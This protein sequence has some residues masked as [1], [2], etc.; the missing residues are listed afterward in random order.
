MPDH[1]G[2]TGSS[3]G[4]DQR[5]RRL[6]ELR[7]RRRPDQYTWDSP[8]LDTI[9]ED[10]EYQ[11]GRTR[12]ERAPRYETRSTRDDNRARERE[13]AREQRERDL[14]RY[15][16]ERDAERRRIAE[17]S[18]RERE[19]ER[20]RE[21]QREQERRSEYSGYERSGGGSSRRDPEMDAIQREMEERYDG[22][23]RQGGNRRS[24]FDSK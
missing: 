21:R 5:N 14:A 17:E 23:R 4:R 6:R 16:R 11:R 12:D 18:Q 22:S 2:Y 13:R 7:P 24:W 19:R 9:Q 10:Q 1:Y 8:D 15:Q 20:E 3:S